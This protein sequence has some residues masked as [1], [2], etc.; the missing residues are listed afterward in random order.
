MAVEVVAADVQHHRHLGFQ[1]GGALE[2]KRRQLGDEQHPFFGDGR[3]RRA[4][5]PSGRSAPAGSTQRVADPAGDGRLAGR[6]GHADDV[7]LDAAVDPLDFADGLDAARAQGDE[8]GVV[9][10]DAGRGD[11]QLDF[12]SGGIA[13]GPAAERTEFDPFAL[14]RLLVEGDD[15]MVLLD[16]QARD[17]RPAAAEAVDQHLHTRPPA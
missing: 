1:R 17:R 4:D 12:L 10:G 15:L 13:R 8:V 2:L 3:E 16:E 7:G 6:A 11:A 14:A 9:E 5:V